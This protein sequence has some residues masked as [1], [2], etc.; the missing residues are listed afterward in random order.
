VKMSP[1]IDYKIHSVLIRSGEPGNP[2]HDRKEDYH[3]DTDKRRVHALIADLL[4][5]GK[6]VQVFHND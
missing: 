6:D 3:T 2:T 4:K 5:S 1:G